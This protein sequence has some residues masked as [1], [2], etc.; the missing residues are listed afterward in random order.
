MS[1][2]NPAD[3]PAAIASLPIWLIWH[4]ESDAKNPSAKPRKVPYYTNNTRR[5][6]KN[7]SPE[8]RKRLVT[9]S[10][11][12]HAARQHGATGVGI[13]LLPG[14]NITALD[15]DNCIDTD[16]KIHPDLDPIISQTY[17]ER[18]P[19][20]KGVR[21]LVRGGYGDHK[22]HGEPYGFEVF[23]TKGFVTI[24][25]NLLSMDTDIADLDP[26]VTA[27]CLARF[28][29]DT[30]KQDAPGPGDP[31]NAPLGW[32]EER[33]NEVL[34]KI[35]PDIKYDPW[36]KV[37]MGVH[38]ESSGE[39]FDMW[40]TW[41]AGGAKYP[42]RD[43]LVTHWTSFNDDSDKGV[44]AATLLYLAGIPRTPPAESSEFEDVTEKTADGAVVNRFPLI[45]IG[46][47]SRLPPPEWLI[48]GVIPQAPMTL[49]YGA[50][51]TGKS[52]IAL[53]MASAIARGVEWRGRKVKKAPVVYIAA[54]DSANVGH[55]GS[56]YAR[57]HG[58]DVDDLGIGVI[59]KLPNLLEGRDADDVAKSINALHPPGP[60]LVIID[61]V[62]QVT[63]GGDENSSVDMGRF[64]AKCNRIAY[65]T[66][67][68]MMPIHHAGKDASKGARGWSGFFAACDAVL[69]VS[70]GV[71]G[72]VLKVTKQKNGV[73]GLEFGFALKQVNM[74][75]DE[76]GDPITSCVVIEAELPKIVGPARKLGIHEVVVNAVIQDIAQGRTTGISV[77]E[78][79]AES[80][81]RMAPPEKD[82]GKQDPRRQN[83]MRALRKLCADPDIPYEMVD[84][85][86]EIT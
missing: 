81:T 31:V 14:S 47:L 49:I 51:G 55:R 20:G 86:I 16:G 61:T 52:F 30:S 18:S 68:T 15:F 84:D 54:E 9:L 66:G 59:E 22:D 70:A 78:V 65:L 45:P 71:G 6:G 1:L 2:P 76:D 28:G 3:I 35:D 40:N 43:A 64:I 85:H 11:A 42:G 79:I 21:A 82:D 27:L 41:S 34:A 46:E 44:T 4:R 56:A 25:G 38:H 60:G 12:L 37:G 83:A 36:I 5:H 26:E 13:A 75:L 24:T 80:V 74:G 19:S 17:A 10:T 23:S 7:G 29:S 77:E 58:F 32:S 69:E 72:N 73:S 63:A 8:D 62:A 48:K 39:G 50:S 67:K 57:E 53:D 33:I